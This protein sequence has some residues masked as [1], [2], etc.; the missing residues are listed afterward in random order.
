MHILRALF[1]AV[2]LAGSCWFEFAQDHSANELWQIARDQSDPRPARRI[3]MLGNSRLYGNDMPGMLRHI[4]DSARAP[5]KYEVTMIAPGGASFQS[6][7]DDWRV[8]REVGQ[9]WDDAVFQGES[10]GQSSTEQAAN[11]MAAGANLIGSVHPRHARPLLIVNWA[12]D[13]ALYTDADNRSDSS[14]VD[15]GRADHYRMIQQAHDELARRTGAHAVNVGK[16]WEYL[17]ANLPGVPLTTDGNHPTV[18]AS[19]F[20]ALCLYSDLSG[21]NVAAVQWAPDSLSP[22]N[23]A[24][25]RELVDRYRAD[26]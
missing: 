19:Y 2:I 25:I 13:R 14:A 23:A 9:P 7:S 12:Y 15:Q 11:F 4:A 3:L 26:L 5:E 18:A 1:L 20:V 6:L 10:R 17:H 22:D 16:V 21:G 8:E 24:Q